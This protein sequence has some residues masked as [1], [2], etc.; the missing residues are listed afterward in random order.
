MSGLRDSPCS[1]AEAQELLPWGVTGRLPEDDVT[2]F[3][4]HVAACAQCQADLAA[5]RSIRDAMRRSP[6]IEHAPQASLQKLLS[7]IDS[8][9]ADLPTRAESDSS[10]RDEPRFVAGLSKWRV[11]AV[12]VLG[13]AVGLLS[14]A[15]WK[16]PPV[17]LPAAYTTASQ[18]DA[19]T[20][21]R[22]QLRVVFS[23]AMTIDELTRVMRES[24]LVIVDGPTESGVYQLAS[25][26]GSDVEAGAALNRLRQD[27]RVRFAEP[28]RTPTAT[29]P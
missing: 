10:E 12:A 2:R 20:P 23:P 17:T 9:E 4:A 13:V 21:A 18:P 19:V 22:A 27:P 1:H 24:R 11:A 16:S 26:D 25:E 8:G 7:R 6:R 28:V 15:L 14:A 5:E 3:E 29:V